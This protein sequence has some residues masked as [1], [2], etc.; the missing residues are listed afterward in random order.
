M[1]GKTEEQV[2]DFRGRV[3]ISQSI[4][5]KKKKKFKKQ[6]RK[7]EK[8]NIHAVWRVSDSNSS[9]SVRSLLKREIIRNNNK[10]STEQKDVTFHIKSSHQTRLRKKTLKTLTWRHFTNI[11]H[12][13]DREN[14]KSFQEKKKEKNQTTKKEKKSGFFKQHWILKDNHEA[15]FIV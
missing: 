6:D 11:S 1:V 15:Y 8:D 12:S 5:N 14:S 9:R 4:Q 3:K 13:R 7:V 2:D 10:R